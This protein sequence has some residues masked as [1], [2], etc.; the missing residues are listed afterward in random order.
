MNVAAAHSDIHTNAPGGLR[1]ALTREALAYAVIAL[2]A[3]ALRAPT[4]GT[5]PLSEREAQ[6]AMTAWRMLSEGAP[7]TVLIES[8]LVFAST[9]LSFAI[10]G[11][12]NTAARL[13]P[14]LAGIG[15]VL[16]PMVFRNMFGRLPML[17]ASEILVVDDA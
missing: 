4:L 17:I 9:V 5:P 6:Q 8:P 1:I 16:L 10:L 14:L 15:L 12:G 11:P 3:I 7:D 2:I 13:L